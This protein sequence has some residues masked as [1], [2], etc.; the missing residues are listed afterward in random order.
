MSAEESGA[1][2]VH[3]IV[4]TLSLDESVEE[5]DMS[6]R[7]VEKSGL[8]RLRT[9]VHGGS[10]HVPAHRAVAVRPPITAMPRGSLVRAAPRRRRTRRARSPG[11][12]SDADPEPEHLR[13]AIQRA[14][15]A[16]EDGEIAFAV[17][18]LLAALEDTR[19]PSRR[20]RC[21]QCGLWLQWPGQLE[22]HVQWVHP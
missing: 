12:K 21:P 22:D 1:C 5:P 10:L 17:S 16:L 4:V 18:C 14:L 13:A 20:H 7:V 8:V 6:P 15:D 19:Q 11:S 3:R 2:I 9:G